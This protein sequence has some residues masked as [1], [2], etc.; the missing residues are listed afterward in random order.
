MPLLLL[1]VGAD[2]SHVFCT[3]GAA[4]VI[5]CYS[6]ELIVHPYLPDSGGGGV[7]VGGAVWPYLPAA[8]AYALPCSIC[9]PQPPHAC[10][11]PPHTHPRTEASPLSMCAGPVQVAGEEQ[12]ARQRAAAVQAIEP[13]LDRFDA[14]VIGPGLGRDP[15]V[16]STVAEVCGGQGKLG[17][18]RRVHKS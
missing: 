1:Q 14:V 18:I 9:A 6:P 5:K 4:T 17:G 13:W 12:Q 3:E 15:L 16:L 2:I 7:G 11:A 10:C 8:L